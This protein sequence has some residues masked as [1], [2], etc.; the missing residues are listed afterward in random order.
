MSWGIA[1][2]AHSLFGAMAGMGQAQQ[3]DLT[4]RVYTT[5]WMQMQQQGTPTQM[6]NIVQGSNQTLRLAKCDSQDAKPKEKVSEFKKLYNH[7]FH[8]LLDKFEELRSKV[9]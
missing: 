9:T 5:Q 8:E 6:M 2:G 3:G 4:G 7:K 1:G